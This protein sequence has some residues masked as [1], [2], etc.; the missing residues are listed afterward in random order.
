MSLTHPQALQPESCVS[1]ESFDLGFPEPYSR[2]VI[3]KVNTDRWI[4]DIVAAVDEDN[5]NAENACAEITKLRFLK[6]CPQRHS[7]TREIGVYHLSLGAG[8]KQNLLRPQYPSI[9]LSLS[10]S[11]V[12]RSLAPQPAQEIEMDLDNLPSI[13]ARIHFQLAYLK[14]NPQ[15]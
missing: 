4:F 9:L 10:T 11:E 7:E 1:P 5:E 13:E 12:V 3:H 14:R 2:P 6:G 15:K 8:N